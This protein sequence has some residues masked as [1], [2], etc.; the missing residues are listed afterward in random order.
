MARSAF[1]ERGAA[2]V[3]N[4]LGFMSGLSCSSCGEHK[5][6]KQGTDEGAFLPR[7]QN[8]EQRDRP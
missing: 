7:N 3:R 1:A 2:E 8:K 6:R 4:R 5:V